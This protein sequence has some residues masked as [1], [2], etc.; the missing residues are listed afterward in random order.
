M[1]RQTIYGCK[2][3]GSVNTV[4]DE[5]IIKMI[6]GKSSSLLEKTKLIKACSFIEETNLPN[7]NV[8]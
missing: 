7:K 4:A 2:A 1:Y 5:S 6:Q 8:R 3:F